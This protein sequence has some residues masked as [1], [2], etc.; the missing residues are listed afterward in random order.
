MQ[1]DLLTAEMQSLPLPDADIRFNATWLTAEESHELH[2]VFARELQWQQPVVNVYGKNHK[3]PRLNAWYGNPGAE[4]G[5]SGLRLE[6]NIWHPL[7]LQL[8]ER[9]EQELGTCFNSVLANWYRAGD[10]GIGWHSDNESELGPEPLI[11]SVSLGGPRRFQL[12]HRVSQAL[13]VYSL[14]LPSGSLLIMAGATQRY[15]NHQVPKT[16]RQVL[17]R[18][19]LTFR[20]VL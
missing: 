15:W 1:Q 20:L 7:L 10:D 8:K 6:L 4:Y 18:I 2:K 12:R 9:L 14:E 19:N 17:S 5:Y 3:I 13:S 11:A 16:K